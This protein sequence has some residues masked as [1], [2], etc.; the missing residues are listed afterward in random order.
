MTLFST[1]RKNDWFKKPTT[2]DQ[3]FIKGTGKDYCGIMNVYGGGRKAAKDFEVIKVNK[4]KFGLI[5]AAKI[6]LAMA[7][8][9][10]CGIAHTDHDK[11][12]NDNRIRHTN[13]KN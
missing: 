11:C 6:L 4:K 8:L 5:T 7:L 12:L 13:H 9:S 2:K 1:L 10:G 3:I